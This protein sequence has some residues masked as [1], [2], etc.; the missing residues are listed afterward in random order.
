MLDI[1]STTLK[2]KTLFFLNFRILV[3]LANAFPEPQGPR[4]GP[5]HREPQELPEIMA[6]PGQHVR[7]EFRVHREIRDHLVHP[8]CQTGNS[9]P[10]RT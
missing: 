4:V 3:K 1:I 8:G 5:E 10:G 2:L 9:V 6:Y 7:L